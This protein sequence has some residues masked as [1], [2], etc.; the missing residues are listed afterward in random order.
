M[1]QLHGLGLKRWSDFERGSGNT[2]EKVFSIF[3]VWKGTELTAE[4]S[5]WVEYWERIC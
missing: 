3:G 2:G 1:E 5:I 4:G